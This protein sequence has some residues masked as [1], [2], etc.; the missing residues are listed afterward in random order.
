MDDSEEFSVVNVV[1]SFSWGERLR[2]VRTWVPFAVGVGLKKDGT[3]SILRG[4][5]SN[6][7]G[8]SRV[9]EM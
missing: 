7:K 9:R 2:E 8:C 3:R 6:G 4:V 1:V 5:R